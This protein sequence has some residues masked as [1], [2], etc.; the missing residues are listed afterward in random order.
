[1]R[2]SEMEGKEIINI[3]DGEKLGTVGDSDL[4]FAAETGEIAAIILP[5]RGGLLGRF[6]SEPREIT[7]P[8]S[9]VRKIGPEVII[10]ELNEEKAPYLLFRR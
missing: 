8:W 4:S 2:L 3:Y 10:V 1:M 9:A 5:E 6:F 7:V